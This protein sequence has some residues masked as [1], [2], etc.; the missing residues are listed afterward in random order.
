MQRH[1]WILVASLAFASA[2]GGDDEGNP[3]EPPGPNGAAR[4]GK[5]DNPEAPTPPALRAR[6]ALRVQSDVETRNKNTGATSAYRV[7]VVGLAQATQDGTRVSASVQACR[8]TLPTIADRQPTVDEATLQALPPVASTGTLA[9]DGTT[10]SLALDPVPV[11]L[12]A[13]LAAPLTDALPTDAADAR[14]VDEDG[15]RKPGMSIRVSGFKVYGALRVVLSQLAGPL[16]ADTGVTGGA[17]LEPSYEIYGDSIPFYDAKAAADQ[18]R[19]ET[20]VTS[21]HDTFALVPVADGAIC[22]DVQDSLFP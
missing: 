7:A 10:W 14:I 8:A 4:A 22:A 9:T 3:S 17:H 13:R 16:G 21:Q 18:A 1:P 12:G 11:V 20:E 6:Y 5:S 19:V 2:C 15:D